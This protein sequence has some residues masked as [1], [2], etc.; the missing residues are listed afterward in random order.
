M[1]DDEMTPIEGTCSEL[2]DE[3]LDGVSGGLNLF[4]SATSFSQSNFSSGQGGR[5]GRARSPFQSSIIKSTAFQI[6][7]TD[8]TTEDL[9]IIAKLLGGSNA[10]SGD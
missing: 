10:L 9:K 4:I 2:S 7:I 3:D 5:C 1:P 8:A 6:A